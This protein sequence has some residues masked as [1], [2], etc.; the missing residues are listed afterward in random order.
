MQPQTSIHIMA[1]IVKMIM[2]SCFLF[3]L[4]FTITACNSSDTTVKIEQIN[5]GIWKISAGK[6]E[7][8]NLLSELD[9]TPRTRQSKRWEKP[10]LLLQQKK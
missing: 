10:F 8:V 1:R 5:A 3:Y 6:P 4:F 2:T 9:I 7:I